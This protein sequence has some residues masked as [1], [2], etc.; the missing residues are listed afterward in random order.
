MVSWL[1]GWRVVSCLVI[2]FLGWLVSN[3]AILR[4]C[5]N[6]QDHFHIQSVHFSYNQPYIPTNS[7]N[8]VYKLYKVSKTPTCFGAEAPASGRL[9]YKGAQAPL[10]DIVQR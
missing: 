10:F 7:Y 2:T 4:S 1:I 6:C 5:L 8:R 3:A 9:K